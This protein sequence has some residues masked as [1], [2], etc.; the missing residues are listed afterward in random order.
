MSDAVVIAIAS[1]FLALLGI[2]VNGLVAYN[3]AK[4]NTQNRE[5][6]VAAADN[7]RDVKDN[8]AAN[9][10]NVGEKL[11]GIKKVTDNV[12]VLV[13]SN[14]ALQLQIS[15]AALRRLALLTHNPEDIKAADLAAQALHNHQDGQAE[16]D[17]EEAENDSH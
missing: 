6:A 14:M 8:L 11:N 5:S 4:L 17:V 12:H 15:A 3:V 7:V 1:G 2:V 13:N 16:A 10:A 9:D